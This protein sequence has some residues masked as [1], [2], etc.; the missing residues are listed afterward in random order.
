MSKSVIISL[1]ALTLLTGC[2]TT[3]QAEAQPKPKVEAVAPKL[4]PT[5]NPFADQEIPANQVVNSKKSVI[6]G[7]ID[8][9]LS[10]I[11]TRFGEVPVFLGKVAVQNPGEQ[12][13]QVMATMTYNP[14][15]GTFTFFE[16]M[17]MEG[18]LLCILS[19][20][21]GKMKKAAIGSSL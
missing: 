7:R 14:K 2:Q 9:I 5:Q 18:R 3:E 20:G 13:K 21:N 16:Q 11:E 8:T 1:T 12:P 19:S 17:P 4:Q 10:R 6:C 15:T